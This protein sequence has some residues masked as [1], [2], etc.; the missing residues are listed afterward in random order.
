MFPLKNILKNILNI[1]YLTSLCV[2]LSDQYCPDFRGLCIFH[3]YGLL[4]NNTPGAFS[5]PDRYCQSK[6]RILPSQ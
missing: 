6:L 2:S 4:K 5:V 1:F 3:Q